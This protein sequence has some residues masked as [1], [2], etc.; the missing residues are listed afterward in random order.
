MAQHGKG[1]QVVDQYV[2]VKLYQGVCYKCESKYTGPKTCE[3]SCIGCGA[4]IKL[5]DSK[6]E[7][8]I[9]VGNWFC[10]TLRARKPTDEEI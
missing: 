3:I 6:A 9:P 8:K 2:K 5:F 1:R 10:T 7:L 4:K